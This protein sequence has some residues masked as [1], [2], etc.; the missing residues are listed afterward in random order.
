LTQLNTK[1]YSNMVSCT[2]YA[3]FQ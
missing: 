2:R 3:K 1:G